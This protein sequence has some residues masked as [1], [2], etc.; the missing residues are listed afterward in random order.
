M[1]VGTAAGAII[2]GIGG[3]LGGAAIGGN[4]AENAAGQQA[5]A[6]D[7]TAQLQYEESQN[8]L[9][10]QENQWNTEQ[11]NLAPW[12][13]SGAGALSNLDYLLGVNPQ[14]MP[15]STAAITGAN[16][17]GG[18]NGTPQGYGASGAA[19]VAGGTGTAGNTPFS[20]SAPQGGGGWGSLL[21]AY[22]GGQF[23]APTAQQA[24]NSPGEQAQL[25]L[26]EQ[27]LQQS[28]AAGGNL[29]TGG[30][31]EALNSYAQNL[32]STNYQNVYNQSFNTY[33]S[34]YNQFENQQA[35]EYNRLASLAGVGQTAASQLG[36]LGQSASNNVSSNLLGTGAQI[37][38]D[39]Q[40]AAAANASGIVGSANAWS[41]ALG[42][43]ANSLSQLALLQE[44]YGGGGNP[45]AAYGQASTGLQT[46]SFDPT[47]TIPYS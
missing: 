41:G 19:Q 34:N 20:A 40:N 10:F 4:A 39:Y 44:L 15:Y 1:G 38:Q 28:A 7:Y 8:A 33:A 18:P 5:N 3:S 43:S 46:T 30:T 12:L 29:L 35:N 11:N 24:L 23:V 17:G 16:P 22:P 13:Q 26:G 45:L 9:G 37:G 32:A 31:A 27:A 25:Q 42:G 36:T 6:A 14:N 21:A 47:E 2:G